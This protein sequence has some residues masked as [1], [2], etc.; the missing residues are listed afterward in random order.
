L[1]TGWLL[2]IVGAIVLALGAIAALIGGIGE[3]TYYQCVASSSAS[4]TSPGSNQYITVLLANN[5]ILTVGLEVGL[6]GIV[7]LLAGILS[8]QISKVA[9]ELRISMAPQ[10]TCPKCG[11]VVASSAKFCPTCGTSLAT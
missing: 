4:C 6:M 8:G 1:H 9:P 5:D 11:T 10:R 3:V 2:I 7:I